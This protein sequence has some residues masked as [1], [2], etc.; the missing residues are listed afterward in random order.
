MLGEFVVECAAAGVG[1]LS[2]LV[3]AAAACLL[4]GGIHGINQLRADAL[5]AMGGGGVEVLQVAHVME[6]RGVSV[7]NVMH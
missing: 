6:P 5:A 4:S 2:G 3:N 7:K 1:G